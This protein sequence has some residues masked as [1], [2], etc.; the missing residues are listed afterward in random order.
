MRAVRGV[1]EWTVQYLA[2]RAW[3]DPD[4]FPARDLALR[5]TMGVAR[6]ADAIA[7]AASW[8]PYRA[9]ATLHLWS[10]PPPSPGDPS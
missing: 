10:A 6:E 2:M 3:H 5:R 1:G 9:Y 4:A 8:R 7:R